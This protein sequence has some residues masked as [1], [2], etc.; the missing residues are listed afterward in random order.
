MTRRSASNSGPPTALYGRG[1][2]KLR[3][4]DTAG[5]K[6]DLEAARAILPQIDQLFA[7]FGLNG[8][9]RF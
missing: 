6:T 9:D 5:A 2:A 4:G 7:R 8:L 3:K 1:L